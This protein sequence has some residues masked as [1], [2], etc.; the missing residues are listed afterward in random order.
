MNNNIDIIIPVFTDDKKE[1]SLSLISLAN[2]TL[3]DFTVIWLVNMKYQKAFDFILNEVSKS[4]YQNLKSEVFIE[5]FQNIAHAMNHAVM[6]SESEKFIFT[7]TGVIHNKNWFETIQNELTENRA[8]QTI[9]GN[10]AGIFGDRKLRFKLH[11]RIF[12]SL[13][14]QNSNNEFLDLRSFGI[15]RQD[16]LNAGMFNKNICAAEDFDLFLKLEQINL[17]IK[18]I[19]DSVLSFSS[20]LNFKKLLDLEF[21]KAYNLVILLALNY[22]PFYDISKLVEYLQNEVK[23]ERDSYSNFY[24]KQKFRKF[25]HSFKAGAKKAMDEMWDYFEEKS[26]AYE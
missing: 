19:N 9:C 24:N 21:Q 5:D 20:K 17:N 18:F 4:K 8:V 15:W 13:F 3:S 14:N 6:N 16:F 11:Y 26:I 7:K 22:I 2:Q 1:I 25:D 23:I 10:S 12:D